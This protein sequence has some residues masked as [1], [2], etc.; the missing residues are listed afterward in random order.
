M[1]EGKGEGERRMGGNG[2]GRKMANRRG[3]GGEKGLR[4]KGWSID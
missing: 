1:G 2:A 3:S 4:S